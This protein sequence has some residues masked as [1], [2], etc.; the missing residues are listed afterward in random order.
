MTG[1]RDGTHRLQ[2]LSSRVDLQWPISVPRLIDTA[3]PVPP[4]LI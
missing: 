1:P 3:D 4:E 2:L